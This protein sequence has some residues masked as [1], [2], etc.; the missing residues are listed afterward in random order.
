MQ[1][2]TKKKTWQFKK[3][4]NLEISI[5]LF[6]S[7]AFL[8]FKFTIVGFEWSSNVRKQT[9]VKNILLFFFPQ[10]ANGI[11]FGKEF[12]LNLPRIKISTTFISTV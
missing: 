10:G 8:I 4:K 12:G 1:D 3:E 9:E 6:F 2:Q 7:F 5:L 11:Y